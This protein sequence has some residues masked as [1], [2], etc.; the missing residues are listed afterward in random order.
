MMR[1]ERTNLCRCSASRG[2]EQ[3]VAEAR[4]NLK[5]PCSAVLD[6]ST[7]ETNP[8]IKVFLGNRP[9]SPPQKSEYVFCCQQFPFVG[10]HA[11]EERQ[12]RV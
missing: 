11:T 5:R 2:G 8:L 1:C 12:F 4:Q 10:D 9:L 6:F 3:S 7:K